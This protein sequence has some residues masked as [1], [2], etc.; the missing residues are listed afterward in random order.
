MCSSLDAI[1][2]I[3][4]TSLS[5][6]LLFLSGSIYFAFPFDVSLLIFLRFFLGVE[7]LDRIEGLVID[8]DI[9]LL[10]SKLLECIFDGPA[11]MRFSCVFGFECEED[12]DEGEFSQ[13]EP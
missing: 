13:F 5:M 3:I 9:S 11:F 10:F 4:A 12:S 1:W 7:S 8:I 6:V 2:E